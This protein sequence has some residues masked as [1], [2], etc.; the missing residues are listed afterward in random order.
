MSA[1]SPLVASRLCNACGLCCN[2]T[3]FHQVRLQPS[4]SA[5]ALA[6]AGLLLKHK[7]GLSYIQQ[8]C[9]SFKSC[10]SK[11]L[12]TD[13]GALRPTN[14]QC[15]IYSSRPE[16]CRLFECHQLK[17]LADGAITEEQAIN[18]INEARQ[19]EQEVENLL[20]LLGNKKRKLPLSTRCE[21]VLGAPEDPSWNIQV[22]EIRKKLHTT[23]QLLNRLLA[24]EFR[25]SENQSTA[26]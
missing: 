9:P 21:R 11:A 10:G 8:P 18:T 7:R 12:P 5:K 6:A 26:S 16:R 19:F 23:I 17:Q 15:A 24:Q 4:D 1:L 3:M 20:V 25:V 2:G 22:H 13:V 14:C